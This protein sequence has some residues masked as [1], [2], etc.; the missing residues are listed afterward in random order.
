MMNATFV[1]LRENLKA[2]TLATMARELET[3]LRQAKETGPGYDEFLLEMTTVE[4]RS[5]AE[6]RLNRRVSR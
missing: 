2:L 6:N 3:Q 1:E 5:R 4:L